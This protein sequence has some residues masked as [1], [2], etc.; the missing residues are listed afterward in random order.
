MVGG[1]ESEVTGVCMGVV[2]GTRHKPEGEINEAKLEKRGRP[3]I[4][5]AIRLHAGL[6]GGSG[7]N[8][9]TYLLVE[10]GRLAGWLVG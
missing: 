4:S 10:E 7:G 1:T 2:G 9:N 6:S 3:G 5:G 8:D